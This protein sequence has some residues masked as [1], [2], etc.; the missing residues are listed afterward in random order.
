M[1]IINFSQISYVVYCFAK[2]EHF[3]YNIYFMFKLKMLYIYS[4]SWFQ[5]QIAINIF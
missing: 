1:T 5:N 4:N 3:I 2:Y